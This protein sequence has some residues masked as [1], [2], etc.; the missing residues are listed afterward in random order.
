M[1]P[2]SKPASLRD[3]IIG[4]EEH[5]LR[6]SYF[7][8]LQQQLDALKATQASLERKAVELDQMRLRAEESEANYREL[9]DKS[10]ETIIVHDPQSLRILEA[11]LAFTELFGYTREE[12]LTLY[13]HDLVAVQSLPMLSHIFGPASQNSAN[14]LYFEL[15]ARHKDGREFW[16]A[17]SVKYVSI[18]GEQRVM[19]TVRDV[20][21]RRR[22][23]EAVIEANRQ[24][25]E[26]VNLRTQDLAHANQELS[27]LLEHLRLAQHQIVQGEKLAALGALVAGIAHELNTPI[28]N[29]LMLASTLQDKRIDFMRKVAAGLRRT[30]L[31]AFLDELA[32]GYQSLLSSLN[33]AADLV[34]GFKELAVDQTSSRRR[35]FD[36]H[37]I[38]AETAMMQAPGLRRAGVCFQNEIPAGIQMDSYPGPLGQVIGNL[39]N[40]ALMHAFEG[41]DQGKILVCATL[42][43]DR[44]VLGFA[45][46]GQGIPPLHLSRIFEP[47]FTTKLGQGGS[48]LGLHIVYNLVTGRLCGTIRVESVVGEGTRFFITMPLV[49]N[50]VKDEQ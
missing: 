30:D 11:N 10:S 50:A 17:L 40:N 13:P 39:L 32:E 15:L 38:I 26:K 28:G 49:A 34:T 16:V 47:F 31:N 24:L 14:S 37:D 25:E 7:P 8:Q 5:A 6:K 45:D 36:L 3:Q 1:T 29:S 19:T 41:R 12:V 2:D 4:L 22:A 44:V 23:E 9:F 20:T 18:R 35:K 27:M 33:R 21:D 48:G 43:G 46:N 42:Q